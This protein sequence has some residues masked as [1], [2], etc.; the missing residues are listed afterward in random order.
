MIY[1]TNRKGRR[2]KDRGR[3]GKKAPWLH[4]TTAHLDTF[5]SEEFLQFLLQL[6]VCREHGSLYLLSWV[7]MSYLCEYSW[8]N[9]EQRLLWG[10]ESVRSKQSSWLL[11]IID[12]KLSNTS[13]KVYLWLDGLGTVNHILRSPG[14]RVIPHLIMC[15]WK[16]NKY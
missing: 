12:L 14:P 7:N 3:N 13:D 16:Y 15:I 10:F 4:S 5:P 8:T 1:F 11:V 9:W 6:H 2:Q